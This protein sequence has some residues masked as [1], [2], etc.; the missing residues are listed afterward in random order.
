MNVYHI[1]FAPAVKVA[2]VYFWGCNFGCKGCIRREELGDIHLSQQVAD[3]SG[4]LKFEEVVGILEDFK[5]EGVTFLGGEPTIDPE[6]PK[7]AKVLEKRL[8][9]HNILLTNGYLFPPLEGVDEIQV[10][11]KAITGTLHRDFTGKPNQE[12][13]R[14]FRQLHRA[15]VALR[16]ESIFIPHYIDVEEIEEIARFISAVDSNIPYRIDG[17]IPVAGNPWRRPTPEE[18]EEAVEVA[19]KYLHHVT[20]L[21]GDEGLRYEVECIV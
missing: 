13:L 10:S 1:T 4:F 17:Y 18:V 20:C 2:Y 3:F 19:R 12:V 9:T 5:P 16:A 11:I 7:L 15:G 8:N 21:K 14:N 6:F